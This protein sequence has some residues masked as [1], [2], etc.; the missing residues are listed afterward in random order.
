MS[1]EKYDIKK[2][3]V[4]VC[5]GPSARYAENCDKYYTAAVN[6]TSNFIQET[7][8][9]ILN[10]ACYLSDLSIEKYD[11]IKNIALPE[12]PH[13]VNGINYEPS[14]N[15]NYQV[16]AKLKFPSWSNIELHPFNIQSAKKF[17]LPY[18]KNY[19]FFEIKSSSEVAFK[20]LTYHGFRNFITLGHDPEGGYH[21]SQHSRPTSEGGKKIITEP[22][23][24]ERYKEVHRR[25]RK[26]ISEAGGKWLRVLLPE[27]E[28]FNDLKFKQIENTNIEY[29]D[30]GYAEVILE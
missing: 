6:I 9:W 1:L 4:L 2:P 16:V 25:M 22:D 23:D 19:P 3:I 5:A 29:D 12:F 24:N 20:W 26:I 7:D 21:H 11:T 30:T 13:T 27:N 8:F 14:V 15:Y 18:N 28:K 10:D 17:N